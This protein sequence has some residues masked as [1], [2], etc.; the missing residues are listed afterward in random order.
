MLLNIGMGDG[1]GLAF[2]AAVSDD[3]PREER[4]KAIARMMSTAISALGVD[5][6]SIVRNDPE[7]ADDD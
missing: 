5:E 6:L 2:H 1:F 4:V 3:A 7:G